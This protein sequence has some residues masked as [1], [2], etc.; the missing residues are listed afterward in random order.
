MFLCLYQHK[1]K[2]WNVASWQFCQASLWRRIWP[3][4][5]ILVLMDVKTEKWKTELSAAWSGLNRNTHWLTRMDVWET[6]NEFGC[7]VLAL[8]RWIHLWARPCGAAVAATTQL[9]HL[10]WASPSSWAPPHLLCQGKTLCPS[11][12]PWKWSTVSNCIWVP[13]ENSSSLNYLRKLTMGH[14][15]HPHTLSWGYSWYKHSQQSE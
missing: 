7:A 9:T 13:P 14:L 3:V 10:V 6:R 4:F 12:S 11:T 15:H 2:Q 1:K 8:H 5:S